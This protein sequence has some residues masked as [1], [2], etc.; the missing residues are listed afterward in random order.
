MAEEKPERRLAVAVLRFDDRNRYGENG[1]PTSVLF[2][3]GA[4]CIVNCKKNTK[5]NHWAKISVPMGFGEK[6]EGE[7][8]TED[9]HRG[10]LIELW[11]PIGDYAVELKAYQHHYGIMPC[12]YPDPS[13]WGLTPLPA[14]GAL[15]APPPPPST[16]G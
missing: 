9:K 12:K 16:V 11:G 5:L 15:D 8:D 7:E 4:L 13:T 10:E 6:H 2:S 1:I 14:E 3:G